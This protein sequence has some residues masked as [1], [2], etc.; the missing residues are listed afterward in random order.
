MEAEKRTFSDLHDASPSSPSEEQA[1][2]KQVFDMSSEAKVM[3]STDNSSK[4]PDS[5]VIG[6]ITVSMFCPD[7]KVRDV[8]GKKGSIIKE[9]MRRS[10]CKLIVDQNNEPKQVHITGNPQQI[11]IALTLVQQVLECGPSSVLVQSEIPVPAEAAAPA[12]VA[13]PNQASEHGHFTGDLRDQMPF[14]DVE[15]EFVPCARVG[16]LIGVKGRNVIEILRRTGCRVQVLQDD[17]PDGVDRKI[18]FDGAPLQISLAKQL[19]SKILNERKGVLNTTDSNDG[20]FVVQLPPYVSYNSTVAPSAG[21]VMTKTVDINPDKVKLVI[22]TKGS[23]ILEIMKRSGAKVIVDQKVTQG[24][25][26]KMVY[27]GSHMQTEIAKFL[28]DQIDLRGLPGLNVLKSPEQVVMQEI[29]IF[30]ATVLH[31]LGPRNP[32]LMSL[33]DIQE[34]MEVKITLDTAP[35]M[36]SVQGPSGKPEPTN[37]MCVIGLA[38]RVQAAIGLVCQHAGSGGPAPSIPHI[39]GMGQPSPSGL[40]QSFTYQPSGQWHVRHR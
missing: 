36:S 23:N 8:I 34:Q 9:I 4:A 14:F 18:Q 32:G 17:L 2:K 26:N 40:S 21:G 1:G 7:K 33:A 15:S 22:G 3:G 30:Q 24:Q 37:K 38:S 35:I 11:A 6:P 39:N 10:E 19:V 31:L 27:T 28:V 5:P 20:N 25:N 13:A 16:S 12:A 29:S